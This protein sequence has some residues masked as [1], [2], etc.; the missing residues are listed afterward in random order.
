MTELPKDFKDN[1]HLLALQALQYEGKP[2]DVAIDLM[3]TNINIKAKIK[4]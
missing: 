1:K 4:R 3:V 2:E